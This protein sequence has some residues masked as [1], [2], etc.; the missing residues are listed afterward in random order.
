[1]KKIIVL[2]ILIG[3]S[4]GL[5]GQGL[6]PYSASLKTVVDSVNKKVNVADSV[7]IDGVV[8]MLEDSATYDGGYA[9][10]NDFKGT[11]TPRTNG[12]GDLGSTSLPYGNLFLKTGGVFNWYNGD[13]IQTHSADLITQTLGALYV[14]YSNAGGYALR[15]NNQSSTTLSKGIWGTSYYQNTGTGT[16]YG[17]YGQATGVAANATKIGVYGIAAGGG[18]NW[19]GRFS[20]ALKVDGY[21]QTDVLQFNRNVLDTLSATYG[22]FAA[23]IASYMCFNT[24]ANIDITAD[25]Q[26]AIPT[27]GLGTIIIIQNIESDNTLKLDDGTGLNLVGGVSCTLGLFDIISFIYSATGQWYELYRTDH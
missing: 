21:I 15:G 17:I 2:L 16:F 5:W 1:M 23:N 10:Y 3:C 18:N 26:I 12:S 22:I 13:I 14:D 20:P 4:I 8:V 9:S 7:N 6:L 27:S 24:N 11:L 19:G 25:P